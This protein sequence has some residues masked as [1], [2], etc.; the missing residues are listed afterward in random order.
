[1]T[2]EEDRENEQLNEKMKACEHIIGWSRERGA[3]CKKC[4]GRFFLMLLPRKLRP[5][6]HPTDENALFDD[7]VL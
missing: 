3:V 1:M 2:E 5:L 7:E 4:E 6:S